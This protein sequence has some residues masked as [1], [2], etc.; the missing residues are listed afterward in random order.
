MRTLRRSA[1]AV[2]A[3]IILA[4]GAVLPAAAD[5]FRYWG[6]YQLTDGA[7]TFALTGAGENV[8]AD[9]TV[10][11]WRFAVA[12]ENSS[13]LPRAEVTFDQLCGA[14]EAGPDEKRVGIVVDYGTPEDAPEG[15][16]PPA[17]RGDCAVVPAEATSTDVLTA[18][19]DARVEGG[20]VCGVGGYPSTG[21]GDPVPGDAPTDD[22]QPIEL[23]QPRAEATNGAGDPTDTA[24]DDGSAAD[25]DDGINTGALVGAIAVIGAI[26]T[27]GVLAMRRREAVQASEEGT[28]GGA[29]P[30]QTNGGTER[31]Q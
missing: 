16:Q 24:T 9:G 17:H 5:A 7:W 15:S 19:L 2:V 20:L 27:L 29:E 31:D 23:V 21:C 6:F 10:E 4:L 12:G 13:R 11:G 8:P 18:V 26:L 14:V 1:V 28:G 22:G 3:T 30:D 25:S